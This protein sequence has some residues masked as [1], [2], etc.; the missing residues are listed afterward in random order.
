MY[1]KM[2]LGFRHGVANASRICAGVSSSATFCFSRADIDLYFDE[3]LF[4]CFGGGTIPNAL[5]E[6]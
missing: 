6:E 4:C 1:K 3:N 2:L 5:G